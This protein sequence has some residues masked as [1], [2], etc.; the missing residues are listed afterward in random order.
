MRPTP[1]QWM[2]LRDPRELK[3]HPGAMAQ[4]GSGAVEPPPGSKEL[5][6]VLVEGVG[7]QPATPWDGIRR[8]RQ[9]E[10]CSDIDDRDVLPGVEPPL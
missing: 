3:R 10:P 9:V 1:F 4:A 7:R 2:D 6:F 5:R 8:G